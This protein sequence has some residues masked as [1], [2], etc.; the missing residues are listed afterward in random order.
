LGFKEPLQRWSLFFALSSDKEKMM[1]K[2]NLNDFKSHLREKKLQPESVRAYC[3]DVHQYLDWLT[4]RGKASP[5]CVE[6]E[7]AQAY[8]TFLTSPIHN[9]RP[10]KL[11]SYSTTTIARKIKILRYFYDFLISR[12]E[13]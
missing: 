4:K 8:L 5:L 10:G 6:I 13:P 3:S 11:G 7:D 2:I 1:G 12:T 9:L